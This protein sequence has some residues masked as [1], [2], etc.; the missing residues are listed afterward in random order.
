VYF[1]TGHD[2]KIDN[3]IYNYKQYTYKRDANYEIS[4]SFLLLCNTAPLMGELTR[5]LVHN[6][7]LHVRGAMLWDKLSLTTSLI[8]H[9]YGSE[10]IFLWKYSK[11]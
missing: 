9:K 6:R 5:I 3:A 10:A 8:H 1:C 11:L 4:N 2:L 7:M